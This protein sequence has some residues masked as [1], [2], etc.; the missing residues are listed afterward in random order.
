LSSLVVEEVVD[1]ANFM[2]DY[3]EDRVHAA[4]GPEKYRRLAGIKAEYDPGT[5][6]TATRTSSHPDRAVDRPSPAAAALALR[7]R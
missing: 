2:T 1:T 3:D 6:C 7:G 5:S 4:Y